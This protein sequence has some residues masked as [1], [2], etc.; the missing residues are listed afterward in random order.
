[1]WSVGKLRIKVNK[2]IFKKEYFDNDQFY[3]IFDGEYLKIGN[4]FTIDSRISAATIGDL[5]DNRKVSGIAISMGIPFPSLEGEV[6]KFAVPYRQLDYL[7]QSG[8]DVVIDI[9]EIKKHWDIDSFKIIPVYNDPVIKVISKHITKEFL[10]RLLWMCSFGFKDILTPE[11]LSRNNMGHRGGDLPKWV[12]KQIPVNLVNNSISDKHKYSDIVFSKL[13]HTSP[14]VSPAIISNGVGIIPMDPECYT[15]ANMQ[16]ISHM[17]KYALCI[18]MLRSPCNIFQMMGYYMGYRSESPYV[19]EGEYRKLLWGGLVELFRIHRYGIIHGDY[20]AM[21]IVIDFAT[22]TENTYFPLVIILNGVPATCKAIDFGRTIYTDD[23][24]TEA[25]VERLWN[26]YFDG[27][28]RLGAHT[29]DWVAKHRDKFKGDI[30]LF[31]TIIDIVVYLSSWQQNM[32]YYRSK[33]P[34][35]CY[36]IITDLLTSMIQWIEYKMECFVIGETE[37]FGGDF[38]DDTQLDINE[39]LL[40]V[41][42]RDID[43]PVL[44]NTPDKL[45]VYIMMKEFE[46]KFDL[47]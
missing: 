39:A 47:I 15:K 32:E 30:T 36:E 13:V 46:K 26:S 11:Y 23:D 16:T 22:T 33:L 31:S 18:I 5:M 17:K 7:S 14:N 21:N 19:F 24:N 4:I 10:Y 2:D 27:S 40:R 12:I 29:D 1:M 20:H 41:K 43:A 37:I 42:E 45:P 6:L 35:E 38:W 8:A 34:T 3:D 9:D 25:N 28:V 44:A